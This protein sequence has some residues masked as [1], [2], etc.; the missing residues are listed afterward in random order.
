MSG[1]RIAEKD[2]KKGY[3]KLIPETTD[4]LWIIYNIVSE[5]DIV[6]ARTSREVKFEKS[7]SSRRIS[8]TLAI[9]VTHLEF[10]PFTNRLRIRGIVV[11]GPEKFG[12]KGHYHTLNIDTGTALTIYKD[13]WPRYVLKKIEETCR[14]R[15]RIVLV[16]LDYD[17]VAIAIMTHQGLNIVYEGS[18]RL[19]G[20]DSGSFDT[21]LNKYLKEIVDHIVGLISRENIGAIVIGSPGYIKYRLGE[22]LRKVL[23]EEVRIYYDNVSMGG[24]SGVHEL[25]RRDI[26]KDILRDLEVVKAQNIV[27][28][29]MRLLSTNDSYV[30]YGIDEV[31]EAARN[32]AVAKLVVAETL[33]RQYDNRKRLEKILD[34]ASI[35]KA[36]IVIAPHNSQIERQVMG[37][38][39][40]IA[41]LRFPLD[42]LRRKN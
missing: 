3:V 6:V 1:M 4:D 14:A 28:E 17:D 5:G 26:I 22:L 11:E 7:R 2:L 32:N 10:Q 21:E 40:I 41:I 16:A 20:K 27:E 8:M 13:K 35:R 15:A 29:F 25:S 12:V 31:E 30:A 42:Y 36:E 23:P 9:R 38:G 33:M 37:L 18:S 39:G 19:P 24:W 34:E